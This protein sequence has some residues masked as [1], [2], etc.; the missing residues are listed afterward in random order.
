MFLH[1]NISLCNR[2]GGAIEACLGGAVETCIGEAV[3]EACLGGAVVG[4][5]GAVE[6]FLVGTVE[7]SLWE[8][9]EGCLVGAVDGCLV[10]AVDG[11]LVGAV[12]GSLWED[13]DGCIGEA[14]EGLDDGEEEICLGEALVDCPED[15]WLEFSVEDRFPPPLEV[16]F[17]GGWSKASTRFLAG[18]RALR[19]EAGA[20]RRVAVWRI[21][22][23]LSGWF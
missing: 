11:Q 3:V 13:V 5:L 14:V 21:W 15:D 1:S 2:L 10:G 8:A 18:A 6:G 22:T 19:L 23:L 9:A 20:G 7:G 16:F 17:N 12:E 4:C